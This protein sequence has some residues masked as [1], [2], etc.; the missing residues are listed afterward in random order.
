MKAEIYSRN[1]CVFCDKAKMRLAKH[2]PKIYML[3]KDYTREEFFQKFPNAKTFPQIIINCASYNNV[4]DCELY[5]KEAREVIVE[6]LRNIIRYSHKDCSI[7]HISSDY[8]F[9]GE[10]GNYFESDKPDPLNYYGKLKLESE[11]I[12][13]KIILNLPYFFTFGF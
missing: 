2:N 3:N 12:I 6:G 11:K 10:R 13:L 7:I 4:N 5:R 8:I 9:N 1:N